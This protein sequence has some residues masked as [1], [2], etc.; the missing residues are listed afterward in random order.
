MVSGSLADA[1]RA[2]VC[3]P[4]PYGER[5]SR[6]GVSLHRQEAVPDKSCPKR[7]RSRPKE[8][9]GG[10]RRRSLRLEIDP[11]KEQQPAKEEQSLSTKRTHPR[12]MKTSARDEEY[13]SRL[14]IRLPDRQKRN[15]CH[16]RQEKIRHTLQESKPIRPTRKLPPPFRAE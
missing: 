16:A 11:R 13:P 10:S 7:R 1:R 14:M 5:N 8:R 4:W 15:R 3:T 2:L 12:K 9:K 6:C